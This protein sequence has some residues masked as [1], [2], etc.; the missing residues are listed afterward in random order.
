MFEVYVIITHDGS[1]YDIYANKTGV[2]W[3]QMLPYMAYIRIL[4]VIYTRINLPTISA[5]TL[6]D[7]WIYQL[8]TLDFNVLPGEPSWQPTGIYGDHKWGYPYSHHSF[9]MII[10]P[11]R[12]HPAMGVL[13]PLW[14]WNPPFI[15]SI[16]PVKKSPYIYYTFTIHLYIYHRFH[17]DPIS[18][19]DISTW[20]WMVNSVSTSR[21]SE[22]L[23]V[24]FYH[25]V[26]GIWLG[27]RY[28][29][30]VWIH[31]PNF[32]NILKRSG[33]GSSRFLSWED[34]FLGWYR[35]IYILLIYWWVS[36]WFPYVH[37]YSLLNKWLILLM[38][39][40]EWGNDPQ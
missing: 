39:S 36:G 30:A 4:W 11:E 24:M 14:L 16:S 10:F 27:Y 20:P 15:L 31:L 12:N 29:L 2:Y 40:R 21:V 33:Y 25:S 9:Q 38:L 5:D 28:W 19:I 23:P 7:R 17:I 6:S 1:M 8:H 18:G 3:W 34:V 22:G 35:N 37:I 32:W 26:G 13:V